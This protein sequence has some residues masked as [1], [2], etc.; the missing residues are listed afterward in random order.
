MQRYQKRKKEEFEGINEAEG[1][2]RSLLG[3]FYAIGQQVRKAKEQ[4]GSQASQPTQT[5]I[6]AAGTRLHKSG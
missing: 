2:L 3:H 1:P 5:M 4:Q 6:V